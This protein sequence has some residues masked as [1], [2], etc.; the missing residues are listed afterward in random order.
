MKYIH[1]EIVEAE[2]TT[3]NHSTEKIKE[4][5]DIVMAS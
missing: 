2:P 4:G 3:A 5:E 1:I